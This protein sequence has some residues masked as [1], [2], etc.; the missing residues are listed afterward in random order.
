VPVTVP[1]Y[2]VS[3]DNTALLVKFLLRTAHPRRPNPSLKIILMGAATRTLEQNLQNTLSALISRRILL[4][5]LRWTPASRHLLLRKIWWSWTSLAPPRRHHRMCKA[6][7]PRLP[8]Q[9]LPRA[10]LVAHRQEPRPCNR[11]LLLLSLLL[12]LGHAY[13]K[14]FDNRKN[15]LTVLFLW[16]ACLYRRTSEFT[17]SPQ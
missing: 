1:L 15:T 12:D 5:L 3:Q 10:P 11:L 13:N 9:Q 4:R 2:D 17:C 6:A 8:V 7:T 16:H 14:V